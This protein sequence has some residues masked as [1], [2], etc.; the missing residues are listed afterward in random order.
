MNFPDWAPEDLCAWY[1]EHKVYWDMLSAKTPEAK[2]II[3]TDLQEK[4]LLERLLTK[5]V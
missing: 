3:I 4:A 2:G 1:R 5:L